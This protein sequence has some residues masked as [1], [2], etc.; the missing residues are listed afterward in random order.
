MTVVVDVLPVYMAVHIA[1]EYVWKEHV[2]MVRF[3]PNPLQ[4]NISKAILQN[5][6]NN[7]EFLSLVIISATFMISNEWFSSVIVRRKYRMMLVTLTG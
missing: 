5:L 1:K 4:P 7:Q 6:F 2:L 3:V